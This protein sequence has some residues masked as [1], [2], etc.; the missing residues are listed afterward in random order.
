[1]VLMHRGIVDSVLTLFCFSLLLLNAYPNGWSDDILLTPEDMKIRGMPD[2]T[3]DMFHN[4]WAVWDSATWV[5]GTGE[6]L[7]SK[8]DSM[9]ACL[10]A[11]TPVSNNASYSLAP[12]V[13]V[14]TSNNLQFVWLNDTP[15]GWGLW[16][17]KLAND[18]SVLIPSHQAV[19][20]NN[21]GYPIEIAMNRYNEIN[22][23]WNDNIAG[24]DQINY[25]KLD[26]SGN[27]II[28]KLRV[29]LANVYSY[30]PGIGVDSFANVHLAYRTDN[31]PQDRL[32]YTKLDRYGNILIDNKFLGYGGRPTMI[33]D[34]SQN[35]HMVYRD[36]TEP[37]ITIEYLKLDQNG[38]ILV[39]PI[40]LNPYQNNILVRM[41]MDSLQYL[42]VVWCR[43]AS[44]GSIMYTKLDTNGNYVIIPMPI[45]FGPPA[46]YPYEPQIAVDM[47]NRLH[48]IWMD[49]RLDSAET[50][51]IF[52]KR[53]ENE[54]A[55]QEYEMQHPSLISSFTAVPNPFTHET[56]IKCIGISEQ[57][58]MEV[59]IFDTAGKLVA[60]VVGDTP[61]GYVRWRG[62]DKF[63]RPLP[64][65]VY[66]ACFKG[67]YESVSVPVILLR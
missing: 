36:P 7:F 56:M 28:A 15:L 47:S 44:T 61:A 14:D 42:H 34:H 45:V 22:V 38:N 57:K 60:M 65:G 19:S 51:D 9:G 53:G 58:K 41:A 50:E 66:I 27:P 40:H 11:E 55:V 31:G 17:A 33:A 67:L 4:V 49:Q 24:Y 29:S 21:G 26:S 43:E 10:M 25:T 1:M 6:V 16:H 54:T 62:I 30:W 8:R 2:I 18:G 5:N 39:G 20:G 3:V 32:A 46:L 64:A 35:I 37:G 23:V 13:A 63:G 52:Y 59:N 12:R 48:L